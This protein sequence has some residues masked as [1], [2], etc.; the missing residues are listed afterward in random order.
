MSTVQSPGEAAADVRSWVRP[1][2][3]RPLR[4]DRGANLVAL[5]R[6]GYGMRRDASTKP[7]GGPEPEDRASKRSSPE[8]VEGCRPVRMAKR[9]LL[10]LDQM[11]APLGFGRLGVTGLDL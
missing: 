10:A 1:R 6:Y 9:V 4:L 11:L 3:R 7:I 2:R 8:Q 5:E